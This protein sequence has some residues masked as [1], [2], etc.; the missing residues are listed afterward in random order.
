MRQSPFSQ[1]PLILIDELLTPDSSRF[2]PRDKY[3]PGQGQES[4][5][6]QFVR[7]YLTSIKFNK[8]PPGPMLPDDIIQKTAQLY[9][10]ALRKLT[11]K[12]VE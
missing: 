1:K 5:D 11:G 4:F 6:K 8:Q 12:K 10:E 2:W 7:D 9:R 3:R